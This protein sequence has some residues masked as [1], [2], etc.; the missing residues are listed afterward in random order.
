MATELLTE[1]YS[2]QI[3]G[4]LSCYDRIVI[5]GTVQPLCYAQGMT[6][7]LYTQQIRIFDYT[8]FAELLRDRVRAN[9]ERVASEAGVAIEFVTQGIRKEAHIQA[10][11]DKRGSAPGLV[12]ILSAMESCQAY[13]PWRDPS[14]GKS[15]VQMTTS[16]CLHYYF[17]FIDE[18]LGL[19][20]LRVPTWSPFRLQFYCN[21]H[22]WLAHQLQC[23]G[24]DY[25][26][27][28]NAFVQLSDF[29]RANELAQA[30]DVAQLQGKLDTF[31]Q[32][33]CPVV[34]EL[35]LLYT[36]SV[37]QVEYATDI[38]FKDQATLQTC[39]PHLVERLIQAVKPAD[40]ATFFGR[41]LHGNYQDAMG[42]K[43]DKR[44]LGTR[45][46]HQMGPVTL[47]L[48]DKFNLIL[49]IE[50]TVNDLTFFDQRRQVHHRD[51]TT[52]IQWAPMK[53]TIYSLPPLQEILHAVN[54]RYLKFLSAIDLPLLGVK[55]LHQLTATQ[56]DHNHRYKGFNLLGEE[57]SSLLRLLLAGEFVI[58][59]L[60][61][62]QLRTKLV[63]KSSAQVSHLLKRLRVHG[64]LK[65]VARSFR[66]YLTDFGRQ[67]AALALT[68]QQVVIVPALDQP[69][70]R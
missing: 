52:T 14:S 70:T 64:L 37:M 55:K 56:L 16:K 4:V 31:A 39:Y 26:L 30:L 40:I 43:L 62:K 15:Y 34:S 63:D 46:K 3:S 58:Q 66:Y 24:I 21:G 47:K 32:R 44:W 42:N 68:L 54:Q 6:K 22:N 36:W 5:S 17:Y 61:N 28:D 20:Y 65:K 60:T 45:L 1:R 27:A 35:Q 67:V 23:A 7:Y 25:E 10:I 53:K 51:G 8:Q 69:A 49:R 50:T 2:E 12:H 33:Y 41:K 18:A 13:K 9:A 57:D 48:Y 59:G 38:V 11:L 19:C 29:A